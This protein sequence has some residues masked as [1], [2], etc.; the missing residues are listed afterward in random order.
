MKQNPWYTIKTSLIQIIKTCC[1]LY[2]AQTLLS[3]SGIWP[4]YTRDTTLWTKM[5]RFLIPQVKHR[6]LILLIYW[7]IIN[8]A[9]MILGVL[10]FLIACYIKRSWR[11]IFFTAAPYMFMF[12]FITLAYGCARLRFSIEPFI[13][14]FSGAGWVWVYSLMRGKRNIF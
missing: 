9:M 14:I 3:D 10:C 8:F 1:S 11:S 7:E 4:D 13:I 2:T 5:K 12:V 6:M